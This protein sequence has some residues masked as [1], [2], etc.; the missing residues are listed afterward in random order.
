[1]ISIFIASTTGYS[2]RTFVSLGLAMKLKERGYKIG[3]I[4]PIGKV[5]IKKERNIY[6]ADALFLKE[7]LGL[8]ESLDVISPFVLSYETQTLLFQG[9]IKDA[10]K[11]ILNS[12]RS[13]KNKDF[14]VVG[15]AGDLF[16]GSLLNIDALS[17]VADMKAHVLM[18]EP[19]RGDISA[20][21][22]FGT[23]RIL[24]DQLAGAVFNKVPAHIV[25]YV[26]ETVRP[27]LE[28]KGV[29]IF[30]VFPK[31]H[32]LE[33]VSVR[34]L[35]DILSG[36][37]LC[38]EE[39]LDEFVENFSIG[40]MDVD[41]ALNYFRR[42]P[43]KAVITGAHRADIQ[44]AAMETSTKCVI[45]TGGLATNDVVIGKA[46]AKGI[47]V[48]SVPDDTFTTIDKIEISMGKT[49]IREKRKVERVKELMD[50]E[51]DINRFLKSVK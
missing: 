29:R 10:R 41:S 40:A 31:D 4:K 13:L 50:I 45:L 9:K 24:G 39:K 15:G 35:N 42:T 33:S 3:Y 30:G 17:L 14:V 47:P 23:Y 43:N 2:G 25:G 16:E 7:T 21:S 32:F 26:K 11:H 28:K 22:L 8:T 5:P 34:Q 46:Q 18:V 27:F 1:M 6:D 36:R 38:C 49:S 37:V 12:L 51:F 20:D 19:W 44:L 48:I